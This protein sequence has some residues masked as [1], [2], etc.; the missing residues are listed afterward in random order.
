[1]RK[2]FLGIIAL[3]GAAAVFAV[4]P[5]ASGARAAKRPCGLPSAQPLWIDFGH[6]GS[7]PFWKLFARPGLVTATANFL[8]PPQIRARGGSVVYI[9]LNFHEEIGSPGKPL[10][11]S[12]VPDVA[13][14]LYDYAAASLQCTHPWIALNELFGAKNATPWPKNVAQYRADVLEYLR[15]LARRGAHPLLLVSQVPYTDG[16]AGDWWRQ[17]AKV[18]DLVRE[19][20]FPAPRLWKEGPYTGSRTVRNAFRRAIT[21]FTSIGIPS[22]RTGIMLGFQTGRGGGREGL[23]PAYRWFVTV[24]W[25]ALA[26]KQVARETGL[27]TI[28]SWGWGHRKKDPHPRL[29]REDK[30]KAACVYLWTRQQSLCNGPKAAGRRFDPSLTQ[31]QI[32]LAGGV[33]CTVGREKVMAPAIRRL[34]RVTGDR[35][36]A[37]T[38]LFERAVMRPLAP[39]S[40]AE[41]LRAE[42]AVV[43]NA[44]HGS[45]RAYVA[46]L[47]KAHATV[48]EARDVLADEIV[49]LRVG[50]RLHVP[51][52]SK[53]Q[54]SAFYSNYGEMDARAVRVRP[55]APWLGARRGIAI[56]GFAPERVF[57]LPPRHW[58]SVPSAFRNYRVEAV[59]PTMPL[60]AVSIKKAHRS[61][62]AALVSLNRDDAYRAKVTRVET[63]A[64]RRTA[65]RRDQLP[66]LDAVDLT[67]YL[68]LLG[69]AP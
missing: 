59:G 52:P 26:A 22:S 41:V 58:S 30:A 34:S 28:W 40:F 36:A 38:A 16:E 15:I 11:P 21:D 69:L 56:R 20:Y 27:S 2:L 42:H 66:A 65:C 6:G 7:V 13:N 64:L 12:A 3:A 5:H 44:F 33:R 25:Q 53:G 60:G 39:V 19:V 54:I 9:D 51:S 43:V 61:I 55:A 31:G 32:N 8:Y 17:V 1:V 35:Q 49:R 48:N 29:D 14:G 4:L 37:F 18:S 63:K 62:K 47:R 45:R 46:A 50:Q 10:D 57:E 68:P 67:D 23:K 24:K